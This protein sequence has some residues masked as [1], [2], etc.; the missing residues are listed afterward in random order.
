MVSYIN[1]FIKSLTGIDFVAKGNA[2][3]LDKQAA[4]TSKVAK[5]TEKAKRQLA[6]FDEME[7]LSKDKTDGGDAGGGGGGTSALNCN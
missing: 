5:A 1:A 3:A 6:G 4:S 2:A 7:V